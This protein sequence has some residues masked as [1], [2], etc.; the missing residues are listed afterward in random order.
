MVQTE[1]KEIKS[2][3]TEVI[4]KIDRI[5]SFARDLQE[6]GPKAEFKLHDFFVN[7]K[8]RGIK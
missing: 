7:M 8:E 1:E 6:K 4:K 5:K 3:E 2:N